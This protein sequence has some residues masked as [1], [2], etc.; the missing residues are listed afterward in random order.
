MSCER[1]YICEPLSPV[2][3]YTFVIN[4]GCVRGYTFVINGGCVRGY[5]FVINGA[6]VRGYIA[7]MSN[8]T[9]G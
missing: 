7:F 4:G 5:T 9:V 1:I 6:C 3:G 2:R 8:E